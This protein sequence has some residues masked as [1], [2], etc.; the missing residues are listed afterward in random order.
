MSGVDYLEVKVGKVCIWI[1][2]TKTNIYKIE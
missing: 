1:K 2:Y